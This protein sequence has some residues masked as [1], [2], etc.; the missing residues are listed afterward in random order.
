MKA[1]RTGSRT[2]PYRF[3]GSATLRWRTANRLTERMGTS[4]VKEAKPLPDVSPEHIP[5]LGVPSPRWAMVCHHIAG[6]TGSIGPHDSSGTH[7]RP[8]LVADFTRV[9][10]PYGGAH[11][12]ARAARRA[13]RRHRALRTHP[14]AAQAPRGAS[15]REGDR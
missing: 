3:G 13:W 2:S 5:T 11:Q 15:T 8:T 9:H 6:W 12:S 7:D 10:C 4:V 1:V 14:E